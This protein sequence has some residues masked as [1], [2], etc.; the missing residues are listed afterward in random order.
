MLGKWTFDYS[1][2]LEKEVIPSYQQSYA[3]ETP[4]R[5][6]STGIHAGIYPASGSFIQVSRPEFLITTIKEADKEDGWLVRGVNLS[7]QDLQVSLKPW[8]KFKNMER[9]NLA[10]E[11]TGAFRPNRDGG[12]SFLITGHRI[13][14][15]LL[16]K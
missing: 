8:E 5:S 10:E 3:F 1:I 9:T 14:T 13:A 15:L 6:A 11:K 7:G 4:L 12:V 16:R 2:S